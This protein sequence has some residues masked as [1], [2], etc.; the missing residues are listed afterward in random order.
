MNKTHY[1]KTHVYFTEFRKI[2]HNYTR[3]FYI[4]ENE[5][6][7]ATDQSIGLEVAVLLA[8]YPKVD[9]INEFE[10][11]P[12][13]T[14][15]ADVLA[16]DAAKQIFEQEEGREPAMNEGKDTLVLA[17]I[18]LGY[19]KAKAETMFTLEDMKK[20]HEAGIGWQQ[21]CLKGEDSTID[22]HTL[23][24][25]FIK[26]KQYTFIVEMNRVKEGYEKGKVDHKYTPKII[27]NKLQGTWQESKQ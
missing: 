15:D 11:L 7:Q 4:V 14:K 20:A 8:A 26:P 5:L 18:Q 2:T 25:R 22:R 19:M 3:Q 16:W 1:I 6:H 23:F 12:P 10:N 9:G 13:N 27:G 21:Y 17:A 24:S